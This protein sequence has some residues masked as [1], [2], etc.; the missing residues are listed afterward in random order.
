MS[1]KIEPLIGMTTKQKNLGQYFTISDEL[2]QY[3]FDMVQHKG[4]E[5]L[6]PSFGQ[7]HLLKKFLEFDTDY[8]I[9][10]YELDSSLKPSITFGNE[11]KRIYA[12][13]LENTPDQYF[14]TIIGNP[15]YVKHKNGNLY[16]QFIERCFSLLADEGELIFI[17]PA[18]FI[19]L[20]SAA[21]VIIKMME[22]GSFTDFYFP[23]NEKLFD[24]ASVDIMIFRYVKGLKGRAKVVVNGEEKYIN[25]KSGIITFSSNLIEAD[26]KLISEICDVYVGLVTGLEEV[27]KVP[28]GNMS[29]LNDKNKIDTYIFIKEYPSSNPIINE[30]L[31]ANKSA[32]L[33]RRI[34]SFT[35]KNWFEW[36]APRNI[37]I[38]EEKMGSDCIYVRTIT[39]SSEVA[40]LGKVQHFGGGLLCLI[41]KTTVSLATLKKIVEFLNTKE[42]Q[43]EYIYSGRFKIGHKQ[44]SNV[45]LNKIIE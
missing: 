41:P 8:P 7:G 36:G 3:V 33:G 15:P 10:C 32:L 19:K 22:E 43:K 12:D 26:Q 28:I 29:V 39:R 5:L 13:F 1:D 40:F 18:D 6:E 25:A 2:Q 34:R 23:Q 44:L 4:S 27:F 35:D 31:H 20:T 17:V 38:I 24:K 45:V 11:Q 30:H 21:P 16:I 37:K 42:F 14:M 9:V